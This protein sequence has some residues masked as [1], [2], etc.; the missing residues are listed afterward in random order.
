MKKKNTIRKQVMEEMLNIYYPIEY[1]NS[2]KYIDWMGYTI[3]DENS[4]TYHHITKASTLRSQSKDSKAT[5]NNG[6]ILGDLSHQSLHIIEKIDPNLYD[7]WNNIFILIN[8][9]KKYPSD[10]ILDIISKLQK[11]SEEIIDNYNNQKRH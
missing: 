3:D 4:P 6:A 2:E 9:S 1:R 10:D 11:V 5:L 8:K 7:L